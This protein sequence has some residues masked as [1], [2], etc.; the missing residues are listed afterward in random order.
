MLGGRPTDLDATL[1]AADEAQISLAHP[2]KCLRALRAV[3]LLLHL[4]AW[5]GIIAAIILDGRADGFDPKRIIGEGK[6]YDWHHT[7]GD[8]VL[9]AFIFGIIAGIAALN[10]RPIF[11]LVASLLVC[12]MCVAKNVTLEDRTGGLR[13]T[14]AICALAATGCL[15]LAMLLQTLRGCR[16]KSALELLQEEQDLETSTRGLGLDYRDLLIPPATYT[17]RGADG[18]A[19]GASFGRLIS[20]AAPERCMLIFATTCLMG[21]SIS[22]MAMPAFVG[23]FISVVT[24][25][26]HDD[27]FKDLAHVTM[28]LIVIFIIGALFSFWRG[29]LFTLAGERVVARLRKA[30]FSHILS[31]EISFFDESKLGELLNRLASDTAVLQDA[32]TV[33]VSM[34]LRF[35][36]Q[37]VIAIFAVFWLQW[38]LTLVMLSVVPLIM[39]AAV[40]YGGF[41][42]KIAKR[43]QERLA[44]ASTVAAEKISAVRT[45]RSFAMENAEVRK[46]SMAVHESYIEG[47]K[48]ALGYGVFISMIGLVGQSAI[49]LVLWYGGTLVLRDKD[50]PNGFDAGKLMSFLLYTIMLAAALGGLS[51]LFSSFMNAVGAST[52][53]FQIFDRLT[54]ISNQGG[55]VLDSYRGVL[56]LKEVTF[57][58]PTRPDVLV[59]DRVSLTIQPGTVVALCGPSGSGKSSIISLI[60]R[61]YDPQGGSLLID[62]TPLKELDAS[63]WRKQAA[64]V[65]QEPV[66]FAT[67]VAENITYGVPAVTTDAVVRAAK[68]ANAHSFVTGFPEQY[69]TMVGERGVQLSGGQKQRIAIARALL[70][71]PRMLLLDEATSA[72]DAESEHIVQEAIDRLMTNR[73][74]VV[75]AHRL[76]TISSADTICVVN[77]G[78]IVEKGTHS[79]L[80]GLQGVYKQ[81]VHRQLSGRHSKNG[82][83]VDLAAAAAAPGGEAEHATAD[84]NGP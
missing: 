49:I 63:W 33:N 41:I 48:R 15:V 80:L 18:T 46:Y 36:A 8:A 68:T 81:L 70:V 23:S 60:E 3:E 66:L 62:G 67:T 39:I 77:K 26:H 50:I 57:S 30:L 4:I 61:F 64:L 51:A 35:A 74:T 73:T 17:R 24:K 52:R 34:G 40:L 37:V 71:D 59:L 82:S 75:V 78:R 11:G 29:Y 28:E 25:P 72:L 6:H 56:Q 20:L 53:T 1:M 12:G 32:V 16:K 45:V 5:V 21:A 76:S 47:A 14:C 10:K 43:Y 31:L 44:E 79:E 19:K 22:Q 54:A 69:Q 38:S 2:P 9:A 7:T 55:E 65:A 58:Y 13:A 42:K 84:T 83:Q 27:G